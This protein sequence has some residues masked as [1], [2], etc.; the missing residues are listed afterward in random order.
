[1]PIAPEV[2]QTP[3]IIYQ[4]GRSGLLRELVAATFFNRPQLRDMAEDGRRLAEVFAAE[5]IANGDKFSQVFGIGES[6]QTALLQ[7]LHDDAGNTVN[8]G[9]LAD[10]IQNPQSMN[11]YFDQYGSFRIIAW[12]EPGY[13]DIPE[14]GTLALFGLGLA[15]LGF[16]RRRKAA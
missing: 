8:L 7:A 12:S 4:F 14:P 5:V 9:L 1:M 6:V 3:G 11:A 10:F 15:G 16:V 2:W 13:G